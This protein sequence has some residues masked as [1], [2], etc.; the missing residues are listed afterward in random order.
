MKTDVPVPLITQH[1]L[2]IAV[3]YEKELREHVY[4]ENTEDR[5]NWSISTGASQLELFDQILSSLFKN[6]NNITNLKTASTSSYDA[7]IIPKL[8]EMQFALPIETQSELYEVWVKYDVYIQHLNG[9]VIAT[10]PLTGYGKM[11][12]ALFKNEKEGLKTAANLAF[13]DVGAKLVIQFQSSPEIQ[14]WLSSKSIDF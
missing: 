3:F 11:Q 8:M 12:T 10:L 13:R 14:Q 7:I 6:I 2:D 9:D 4:L 1:P 5:K